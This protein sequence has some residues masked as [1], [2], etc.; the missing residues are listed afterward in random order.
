MKKFFPARLFSAAAPLLLILCILAS[1]AL[2]A[3]QSTAHGREPAVLQIISS[4]DVALE[5]ANHTLLRRDTYVTAW[6][7][8]VAFLQAAIDFEFIPQLHWQGLWE[9]L[10]AVPEGLEIRGFAIEEKSLRIFCSTGDPAARNR[11]YQ[12]LQGSRH[13]SRVSVTEYLSHD[14]EIVFTITCTPIKGDDLPL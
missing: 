4:T 9:I 10:Q 11:F 2:L 3:K 13:L 1:G 7:F 12:A 6:R 5:S 14:G 8:G